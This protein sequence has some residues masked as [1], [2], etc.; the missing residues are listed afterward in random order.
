MTVND[1]FTKKVHLEVAVVKTVHIHLHLQSITPYYLY[2]KGIHT[3][4]GDNIVE[5]VQCHGISICGLKTKLL[6]MHKKLR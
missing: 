5:I 6:E 4:K 1:Y 2:C 3:N